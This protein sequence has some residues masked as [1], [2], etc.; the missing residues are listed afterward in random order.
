L[1]FCTITSLAGSEATALLSEGFPFPDRD[2][3]PVETVDESP[4]GNGERYLSELPAHQQVH[5]R[6][7]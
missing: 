6:T 5:R 2:R 7:I 4:D 3:A 1:L